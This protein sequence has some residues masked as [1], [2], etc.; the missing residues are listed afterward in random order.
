MISYEN[1]YGKQARGASNGDEATTD[2]HSISPIILHLFINW[3][4]I[5]WNSMQNYFIGK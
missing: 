4:G 5:G 1:V 2:L 3:K